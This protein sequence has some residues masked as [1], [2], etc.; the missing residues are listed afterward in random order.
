[1]NCLL[2]SSVQ[3]NLKKQAIDYML[4]SKN[5]ALFN[6]PYHLAIQLFAIAIVAVYSYLRPALKKRLTSKLAKHR[7]FQ[8]NN[9]K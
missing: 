7:L 5:W 8:L 1:M 6:N 3:N 4:K 2:T 9:D